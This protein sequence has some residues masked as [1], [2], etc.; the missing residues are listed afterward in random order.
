MALENLFDFHIDF[1]WG[2]FG[3]GS[4]STFNVFFGLLSMQKLLAVYSELMIKQLCQVPTLEGG[5]QWARF[6]VGQVEI[7]SSCD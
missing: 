7:L 1:V 3:Y 4:E 5:A 2:G 6:I